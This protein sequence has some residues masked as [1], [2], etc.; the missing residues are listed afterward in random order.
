MI[1]TL[2]QFSQLVDLKMAAVGV[3]AIGSTY[4]C[5]RFEVVV[6]MPLELAG[7]AIVFPIVF[8]IGPGQERR[9]YS[10]VELGILR[11]IGWTVVPEPGPALL[12]G[13]GLIGLAR[14]RAQ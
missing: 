11:D 8:S 3:L 7:I 6:D 2:V 4:A 10:D 1:R 9:S 5:L 13:L 12:L 14:R